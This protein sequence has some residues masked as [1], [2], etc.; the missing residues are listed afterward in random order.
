MPRC[1][2]PC[3]REVIVRMFVPD[4]QEP[5]RVHRETRASKV[6]RGSLQGARAAKGSGEGE[7]RARRRKDAAKG[8]ALL[9]SPAYCRGDVLG[10]VALVLS[11]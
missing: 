3:D 1:I 5:E 11:C 8:C 10:V 9:V 4:K 6:V 2:R 7:S